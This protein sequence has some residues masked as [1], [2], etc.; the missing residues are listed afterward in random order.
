MIVDEMPKQ[1]NLPPGWALKKM[2]GM[3][4]TETVVEI[5]EISATEKIH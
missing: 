2:S 4:Q 3:T 5:D 1:L